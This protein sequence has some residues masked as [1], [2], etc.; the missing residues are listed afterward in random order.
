MTVVINGR[1]LLQRA[2]GLWCLKE[3]PGYGP[4]SGGHHWTS[5]WWQAA[6]TSSF[7]FLLSSLLSPSASYQKI[8]LDPHPLKEVHVTTMTQSH[9]RADPSCHWVKGVVHAGQGACPFLQLWHPERVIWTFCCKSTPTYGGRC[10]LKSHPCDVMTTAAI[11]YNGTKT[12]GGATH[13]SVSCTT[14]VVQ[15]NNFS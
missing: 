15:T 9:F 5:G 6:V 10:L 2:A 13:F 4:V 11:L 14:T 7:C 8:N 3:Q 12:E 1:E